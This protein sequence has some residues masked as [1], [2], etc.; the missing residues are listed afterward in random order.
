MNDDKAWSTDD[1]TQRIGV[2]A[3]REV[4]ARVLAPVIERLARRFGREPVVQAVREA[5][6]DIARRQGGEL[7]AAMGGDGSDE[8]L[9]SL[10]Y[11]TQ[12]DALRIEVIEHDGEK[13][14]FDVKRCRYAEMYR[15]LGIP[16]LGE[17]FS[18][19]RDFALVAGFNGKAE[20]TRTQTI[21]QG[22][23]YCDF[24]Y[25]FPRAGND[26]KGAADE[27]ENGSAS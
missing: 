17:V 14:H 5:V 10:E 21:M 2:L 20:L 8:F 11:W 18:C 27:A 23:A 4:E 7:A 16:E 1:L 22:A 15:A 26:Q 6:V 13:L 19:N 25:R 12:G 3:R 9:Q 24:R